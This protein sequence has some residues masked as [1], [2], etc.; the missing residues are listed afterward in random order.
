MVFNGCLPFMYLFIHLFIYL[1]LIFL[2]L[3]WFS[4]DRI[5]RRL[6]QCSLL[7][8]P[9]PREPFS[10]STYRCGPCHLTLEDIITARHPIPHEKK[11]NTKG[12]IQLLG[13]CNIYFW[14][15]TVLSEL[16]FCT[17]FQLPSETFFK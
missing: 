17:Y 8:I 13:P 1:F 2:P 11:T 6:P 9:V 14:N 12:Y 4:L 16:F 15:S 10:M 3:F 5:Y 7:N